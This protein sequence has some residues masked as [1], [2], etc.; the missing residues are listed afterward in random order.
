MVRKTIKSVAPPRQNAE[1]KTLSKTKK[2]ATKKVYRYMRKCKS[3]E[4]SG[5]TRMHKFARACLFDLNNETSL[6][7]P[8]PSQQSDFKLDAVKGVTKLTKGANK[9]LCQTANQIIRSL[10]SRACLLSKAA[11]ASRSVTVANLDVVDK[12]FAF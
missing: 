6:Y 5:P 2:P 8:N 4:V 9:E 12:F 3:V 1:K 7:T 10:V 11:T